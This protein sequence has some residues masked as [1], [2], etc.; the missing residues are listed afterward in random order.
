MG[1]FES[2]KEM[3]M[4]GYAPVALGEAT[5]TLDGSAK[6]FVETVLPMWLNEGVT[7]FC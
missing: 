4:V 6:V 5:Q 2:D 1:G 3:H 7:I